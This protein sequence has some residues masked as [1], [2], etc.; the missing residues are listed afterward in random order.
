MAYQRKQPTVHA[1]Q[2][3][4]KEMKDGKLKQ[5]LFF[6][7]R[8]TYLSNWATEALISKYISPVSKE[9]DVSQFDGTLVNVRDL[10]NTCETLPL[11][12][13]KKLVI[14][15]DFVPLSGIKRKGFTEEDE[16]K[17]I[18]YI[19]DLPKTTMLVFM[20]DT[21]DKRRKL[22]KGVAEAGAAYEF[23]PL[24]E[25]QLVAFI[26][27]RL[28]S[29]E[30]IAKPAAITQ[31]I[32]YT[33]YYDKE[34]D[35]DLYCLENDIK[36][37]LFFSQTPEL[38]LADFTGTASANMDTNVFAMIDAL[39]KGDKQQGFLLLHNILQ[40]GE[41]TYKIL[42]LICSQFELMFCVK[43]MQ[44]EGLTLSAMV[45]T[46][47]VHEFRIKKAV[48]FAQRYSV[49]HLRKMLKRAYEVDKNI[50]SGELEQG[51]A[52]ELLVAES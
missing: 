28:K 43:E 18:E 16:K 33:G 13:E 49:D 22:Y 10:I 31:F 3:V 12:S 37:A 48:Q 44:T 39:S 45:N 25:K 38:T 34:S 52:L 9:L 15:K 1:Y 2:K 17:L 29:A 24:E 50:K 7:G 5:V 19:K 32:S 35:Y 20:A 23:S 11:F 6:Y 8:E 41:N 46:L 4:Q 30:R 42:A 51:L 47:G 14:V 21:A 26:Q 36:K 27:K 40:S